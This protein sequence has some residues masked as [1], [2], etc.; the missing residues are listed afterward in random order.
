MVFTLLLFMAGLLLLY[1]GAEYLVTGSSRLAFSYGIRPLVVGMTVVA[2]ATSTPELLV[3]LL[4]AVKGSA[5]IATGNII[6]SNIANI[7]LILG[8]AALLH[9]LRVSRKTLA[10]EIPIMLLTGIIL[11]L[12]ALDGVIGFGNGLTLFALLLIFLGYCLRIGKEDESG[13]GIDSELARVERDRRGGD[14]LLVLI[15]IVGLGVG[16][17]LMVRSAVTMA[18][19][20]GFSELMIGMTIVALGTSLPELA[21]SMMSAW[22]GEM[23]ISVGNVI[24]SNIFNVLFVLGLCPMIKPLAVEPS[25]LRFEMPYMLGLSALLIPLFW[26]RLELGRGKGAVLLGSYGLFIV[27]M[28]FRETS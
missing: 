13:S 20:F 10:R 19:Y 6:G 2:F 8:A 9:P 27:L 4:A 21:A 11:Y 1:Y 17:E 28:F 16:A 18:R 15:G 3:S 5:D 26:H 7:G 23:D 22:K 14:L 24:G 25:V 12:M